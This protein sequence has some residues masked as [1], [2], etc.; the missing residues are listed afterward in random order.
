MRSLISF[1]TAALLVGCASAPKPVMPEE[2]YR[3]FAQKWAALNICGFA[4]QMPAELAAFG[5]SHLMSWVSSWTFDV[6]R[7]DAMSRTYAQPP[8][9]QLCNQISMDAAGWR[10]A[11]QNAN[12]ANAQTQANQQQWMNLINSNRSAQTYCNS[13]GT[14][15]ICS[16]Y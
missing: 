3:F 11:V 7:M 15:T 2:N 14:Q 1:C 13:I 16:R 9:E 6:V 4:G 5:K 8:S 12:V 10:Q